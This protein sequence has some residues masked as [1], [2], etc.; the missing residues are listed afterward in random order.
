MRY[1]LALKRE[2][3]LM[4]TATYVHV[5]LKNIILN[6]ISKSPKDTYYVIPLVCDT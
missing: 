1:P 3:I 5:N 4:Y 6:E 2:E